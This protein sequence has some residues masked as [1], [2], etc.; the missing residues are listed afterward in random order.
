MSAAEGR[1]AGGGERHRRSTIT[2]TS[3]SGA[4]LV[5]FGTTS[6]PFTVVNDTTITV[7]TPAHA[8]GLVN[9]FV[10]TQ[11]GTNPAVQQD[12]FTFQ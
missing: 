8:A 9:I 2:G 4:T 5:R 12:F 11:N 7:T 1:S 10:S 3:F 6:A